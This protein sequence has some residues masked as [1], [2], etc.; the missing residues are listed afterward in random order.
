MKMQL[1]VMSFAPFH[2]PS[3]PDVALKPLYGRCDQIR[4]HSR[5]QPTSHLV[6]QSQQTH[7]TF[8]PTFIK[9]SI[10]SERPQTLSNFT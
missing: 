2:V 9:L 10:S 7:P 1:V 3:K 5:R 8:K 6:L 4:V